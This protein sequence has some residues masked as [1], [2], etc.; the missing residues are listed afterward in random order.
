LSVGSLEVADG[1]SWITSEVV[2][3][4]LVEVVTTV[5]NFES[6][7]VWELVAENAAE[8]DKV[9]WVVL[10][11]LV[12][13]SGADGRA[14]SGGVGTAGT[15]V[16][17]VAARSTEVT[18][19]AVV[20]VII[21]ARRLVGGVTA[22]EV[23]TV[24]VLHAVHES[25]LVAWGLLVEHVDGVWAGWAD[26]VRSSSAVSEEVLAV[27]TGGARFVESIGGVEGDAREDFPLV[28]LS[29]LA[30]LAHG[31]DTFGVE[32]ISRN[33]EFLHEFTVSALAAVG[34]TGGTTVSNGADGGNKLVLATVWA[35]GAESVRSDGVQSLEVIITGDPLVLTA[36]LLEETHVTLGACLALT[37]SEVGARG[38]A[39]LVGFAG[40]ALLA[41]GVRVLGA[42]FGL[43]ESLLAD[44]AWLAVLIVVT[45]IAICANLVILSAAANI[46]L[47]AVTDGVAEGAEGVLEVGAASSGVFELG[48]FLA[49]SAATDEL[50]ITARLGDSE[51]IGMLVICSGAEGLAS[52][53]EGSA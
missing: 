26:G 3:A 39:V 6:H 35:W 42:G 34:A 18:L 17:V 48:A 29:C 10:L 21:L 33:T 4:G 5:Q 47:L 52:Y 43:E 27:N 1:D 40:S 41:D 14:F 24:F 23:L 8:V 28:V 51:N 20:V 32:L 16:L 25:G 49:L 2:L 38:G 50:T 15:V 30:S 53:Q 45:R 12:V 37:I 11:V 46:C 7:A 13:E 22:G 44:S 36:L 19:H 9:F 31:V